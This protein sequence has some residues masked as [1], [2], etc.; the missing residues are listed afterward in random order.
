MFVV[1]VLASV[2]NADSMVKEQS[3]DTRYFNYIDDAMDDY[4]YHYEVLRE[5]AQ[6]TTEWDVIVIS[7]FA[8]SELLKM[9]TIWCEGE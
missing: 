7:I 9:Q 1:E 6:S 2:F 5:Y 3:R 8:G 4:R